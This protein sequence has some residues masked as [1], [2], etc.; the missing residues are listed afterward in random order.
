MP[1][2]LWWRTFSQPPPA[3]PRHSS[4][5]FPL[6]LFLSPEISTCPSWWRPPPDLLTTHSGPALPRLPLSMWAVVLFT[7]W[8]SASSASPGVPGSWALWAPPSLHNT[9]VLERWPQQVRCIPSPSGALAALASVWPF[10]LAQ[11]GQGFTQR[12]WVNA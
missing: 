8:S 6:L 4:T 9:S 1:T 7:P 10:C 3:P 5:Q 12:A 2:T 11:T